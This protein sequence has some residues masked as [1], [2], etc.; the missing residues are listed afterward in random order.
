[1]LIVDLLEAEL[2]LVAL[3]VVAMLLLMLVVRLIHLISHPMQ[4]QLVT[5]SALQ[6]VREITDNGMLHR[7]GPRQFHVATPTFRI[8]QT[9][10]KTLLNM[11]P[12]SR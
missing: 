7:L 12:V 3:T 6:L 10:Q 1:M 9:S 4:C 8:L 2:R 5:T 11:Q